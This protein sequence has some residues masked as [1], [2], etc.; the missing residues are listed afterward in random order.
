VFSVAA[1]NLRSV[2]WSATVTISAP[3]INN[4]LPG[5]TD[6]SINP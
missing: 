4:F 1:L 6:S 5:G 3:S 2:D